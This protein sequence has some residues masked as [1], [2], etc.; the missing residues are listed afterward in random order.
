MDRFLAIDAFVRVADT[1]SFA[2]AAR[3]CAA[4]DR[5]LQ[6]EFSSLKRLSAHRC[7]IATR[8]VFG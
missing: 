8:E 4:L 1:R 2:Q 6:R 3:R 5:S 7:S